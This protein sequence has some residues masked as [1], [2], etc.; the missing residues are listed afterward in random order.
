MTRKVQPHQLPMSAAAARDWPWLFTPERIA[1][2]LETLQL[3]IAQF[4]E[5]LAQGPSSCLS[6]YGIQLSEKATEAWK[7]NKIRLIKKWEVEACTY[8]ALAMEAAQ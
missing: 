4:N 6:E 3:G 5:E 7:A 2:S 8:Q 1:Q